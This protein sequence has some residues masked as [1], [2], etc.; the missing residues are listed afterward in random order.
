[1]W[2]PFDLKNIRLIEILEDYFNQDLRK[3]LEEYKE[4]LDVLM[5]L[6]QSVVDA[7]GKYPKWK[8]LSDTLITKII[9]HAN[10]ISELLLGTKIKSN[11][12]NKEATLIDIPSIYILL[13]ALLETTLIFNFIYLQ[14]L[15]D[16]EK[17]FRVNNWIYESLLNMKK[18]PAET[19]EAK[20]ARENNL[21]ETK[22]LKEKIQ[23]SIYFKRLTEK[24]G[25]R[26]LK[27]GNTRLF[28]TWDELI[29]HANLKSPLINGIYNFTSNYAHSGAQRIINLNK[30]ILLYND[31]QEL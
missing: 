2:I 16:D 20:I 17:E 25:K 30:L 7:K 10:T 18:F 27:D 5:V 15:T 6:Q 1:M 24:Q 19:K 31:K 4:I 29:I 8:V 28:N 3:N 11:L 26:I 12:L 23:D 9:L 22:I 21:K 13:R 14:P